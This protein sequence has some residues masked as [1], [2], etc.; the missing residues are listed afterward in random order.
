MMTDD[1]SNDPEWLALLA[2]IRENFLTVRVPAFEQAWQH[3]QRLPYSDWGDDL[4]RSVHGLAGVSAMIGLPAIG[5]RAR[6]IEARWDE[7]GAADA[8]VAAA[9]AEL[10]DALRALSQ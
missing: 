1:L 4:K 10:A 3:S 5:D 8:G 9:L 7:Q 6:T 2:G